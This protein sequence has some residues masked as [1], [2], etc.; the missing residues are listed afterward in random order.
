MESKNQQTEE[1]ISEALDALRKLPP[2]TQRAIAELLYVA[3][4]QFRK[5]HNG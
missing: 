2:E 5:E 1:M 3:V 4:K